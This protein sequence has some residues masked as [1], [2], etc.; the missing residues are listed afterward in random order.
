MRIATALVVAAFVWP[1]CRCARGRRRALR[2]RR[3][4]PRQL[5]GAAA[6]R[7][8]R[9]RLRQ[10]QRRQLPAA[11][12]RRHPDAQPQ[13]GGR[14]RRRRRRL[15]PGRR[16]RRRRL[17]LDR[18]RDRVPVDAGEARQL[19]DR[20]NP[21]QED[22]NGNGVGNACE[23]DT[24]GDGV[25]DSEDNCPRPPTR[26]RPIWTATTS[27]TSATTTTTGTTRATPPT[28]ARAIPTRTS[29]TPTATSIGAA[30][31]DDDTPPPLPSATADRRR[32]ARP[33]ASTDRQPPRV[34]V[35]VRT[36]HRVAEVAD[37][38]IVR[39]RCSEACTAKAELTVS[40]AVARSLRLRGTHG[41]RNGNRA[42]GGRDDA[43][44]RSSASTRASAPGCSGAPARCSRSGSPPPI[45]PG[46]IRRETE[47][48]VLKTPVNVANLL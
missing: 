32:R 3:R 42:D 17:R 21:G 8:P 25:F 15:V 48:L 13:P 43:R 6:A 9:L 26:I 36:S 7:R 34:T 4:Q 35:S 24:D 37:G 5:A 10:G 18:P 29:S 40:K 39:V 30:C 46:N 41:R 45:R 12:L 19:P 27:A 11:R 16:R 38:L 22:D 1:C 44:T 28:T 31:D 47:Q 20:A 23:F 33:S 14:G 2:R